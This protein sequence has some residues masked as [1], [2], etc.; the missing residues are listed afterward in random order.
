[1]SDENDPLKRYLAWA[2]TLHG[3][4]AF[5]AVMHVERLEDEV[6]EREVIHVSFSGTCDRMAHMQQYLREELGDS[7][8]VLATVYPKRNFTLLDILPPNSSKGSGLR[9]LAE[10][11][12]ITPDE[13]MVIGDNFNDIEMLEFAG[14]AV[15]MG[16]ADPGLLEHGEFYTTVSNDEGGVAAAIERFILQE[17]TA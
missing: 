7:V 6:P 15:V 1:V 9:T 17:E 14:T 5:A 12:S 4:E 10:M 3:D 11:D 13:I 8:T 16:N 2:Q